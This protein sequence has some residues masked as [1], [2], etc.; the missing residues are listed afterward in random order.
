MC[1]PVAPNL[2]RSMQRCA[3]HAKNFGASVLE[4][5]DLF[6]A[7]VG[8]A[9]FEAGRIAVLTEEHAAAG[10]AAGV[11]AMGKGVL[12][13][14]QKV[15]VLWA[16]AGSGCYMVSA[17]AGKSMKAVTTRVQRF[18]RENWKT[19]MLYVFAW[20]V[21]VGFSG[22]LYGFKAV[23]LPLTIGMGAGFV[24]G[25]LAGVLT[26]TIF[27]PLDKYNGKNSAWDVINMGIN[28]LDP[29]GTRQVVLGI[30]ITV[31]LA[32]AV[33]YPHALGAI[34]GV[35]VGNQLI[36]KI[37]FNKNLGSARQREEDELATLRAQTEHLLRRIDALEAN[38][39]P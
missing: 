37:G 13:A 12:I 28:K 2:G 31:I 8:A 3:S 34:F 39:Q 15:G 24:V 35:L 5:H 23:A 11:M 21:I 10:L 25:G 4:Y 1:L 9:A 17:S 30:A 26:T 33:I 18:V 19:V 7:G 29:N 36:T 16:A 22:F 20:G 32:A 6:L 14:E 38:R 27:D